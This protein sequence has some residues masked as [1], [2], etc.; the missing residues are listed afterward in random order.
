MTPDPWDECA[1]CGHDRD[2]HHDGICNI[3]TIGGDQWGPC[4]CELFVEEEDG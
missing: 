4:N 1:T 2:D 3:A